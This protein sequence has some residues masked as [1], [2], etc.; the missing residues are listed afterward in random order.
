MLITNEKELMALFQSVGNEQVPKVDFFCH[1][2][3]ALFLAQKNT[4]GYS[5]SIDRAEVIG[6][7]IMV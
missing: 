1:Q 5:I 7:Q 4:G 2:V 6:N 3:A